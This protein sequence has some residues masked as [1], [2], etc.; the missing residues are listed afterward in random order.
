MFSFLM[1]QFFG[2][3][4]DIFHDAIHLKTIRILEMNSINVLIVSDSLEPVY[5]VQFTR[6]DLR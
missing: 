6:V 2:G 3:L 5:F 1:V 4:K